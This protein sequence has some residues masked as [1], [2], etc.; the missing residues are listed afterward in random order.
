MSD[1]KEVISI[2][3]DSLISPIQ[4]AVTFRAKNTFFGSLFISWVIWNWDRIAY[5]TLSKDLVL[6]RIRN[7]KNG[8]EFSLSNELYLYILPQSL[9][10]P[11]ITAIAFTLL[12][13]FFMYATAFVHRRIMEEIDIFNNAENVKKIKNSKELIEE[14]QAKESIIAIKTAERERDIAKYKEDKVR[15]DDSVNKIIAEYN[16]KSANLI[17]LERKIK[18]SESLLSTYENQIAQFKTEIINL[19]GVLTPLKE[20]QTQIMKMNLEKS[21]LE[22]RLQEV[23]YERDQAQRQVRIIES[24]TKND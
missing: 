6:D 20:D 23:S 24:M 11:L 21:E 18:E 16:E 10:Y 3:K 4:Q 15:S 9:A 22:R 12:Y 14:N 17:I 2:F 1:I 8:T 5:F 13:P 19:Q 7:I